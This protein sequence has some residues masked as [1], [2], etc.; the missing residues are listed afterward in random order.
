MN[1]TARKR[2]EAAGGRVTSVQE[3]L[4][5]SDAEMAIIE[6]KIALAKLLREQRTSVALTQEQAAKLVG[7]SQ[8]RVAKMEAGDPAVSLDLLVGSLLRLGAS[9]GEVGKAIEAVSVTRKPR[10]RIGRSGARQ[11]SRLRA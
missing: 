6:M 10:R 1:S 3:F 5:L 7:S 11:S 2:I 8:S 9:P 4:G